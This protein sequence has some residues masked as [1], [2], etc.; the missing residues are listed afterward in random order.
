MARPRFKITPEVLEKAE[1]MAGNGLTKEQIAINLGISYSTLMQK[2]RA[3]KQFLQAIK[4]GQAKGINTVANSLFE[5]ANGGNVAAQIFYLKN[6][7]S[8]NWKD[9]QDLEVK[10]ARQ[11]PT[12]Q[13]VSDRVSELV[14]SGDDGHSEGH[15]TH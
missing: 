12:V 5:T 6:R 13:E 15:V 10:D 4:D 2:Q 11:Y 1:T 9:K 14:G 3:N 7:D 8:D